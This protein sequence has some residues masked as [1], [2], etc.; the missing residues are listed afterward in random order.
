MLP[1]NVRLR[2]SRRIGEIS[3]QGR[4]SHGKLLLIK[5]LP[6]DKNSVRIAISVSTKLFPL[7]VQRN[8]I[9][10]LIREA[11][12]PHL[13]SLPTTD[14]LIIAKKSIEDSLS[15]SDIEADLNRLLSGI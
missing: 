8:K 12:K 7:A 15:L 1:N 5:F 11:V 10:R 2:N 3:K 4:Y 14:I 13:A 9:K 6:N